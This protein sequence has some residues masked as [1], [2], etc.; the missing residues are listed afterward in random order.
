MTELELARQSAD[1][2]F[3]S[4]ADHCAQEEEVPIYELKE[5]EV[6]SR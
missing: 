2:N 3:F 1:G 6:K 4:G 5:M